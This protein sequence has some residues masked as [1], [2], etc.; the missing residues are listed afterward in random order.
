[1]STAVSFDIKIPEG[2]KISLEQDETFE[3]FIGQFQ[4][5]CPKLIC[6]I[7]NKTLR[8]FDNS[9]PPPSNV[10]FDYKQRC[11]KIT[12]YHFKGINDDTK[13]C[14]FGRAAAK[15]FFPRLE[16]VDRSS[17]NDSDL[18]AKDTSEISPGTTISKIKRRPI[19]QHILPP[20][21]QSLTSSSIQAAAKYPFPMPDRKSETLGAIL[22]QQIVII[23]HGN[24]I[25]FPN[26]N[27]PVE[28]NT[29]S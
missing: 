5:F 22:P 8:Y 11:G 20:A 27:Y 2:T 25:T 28:I 9:K 29:Y 14:V 26:P 16:E 3:D 24:K 10:R 12:E 6:I 19:I 15:I 18:I 17:G 4:S 1:M 21:I 23:D 7:N 13:Y